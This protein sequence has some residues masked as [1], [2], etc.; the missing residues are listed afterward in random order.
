MNQSLH[1]TQSGTQSGTLAA[2]GTTGTGLV[3]GNEQGYVKYNIEGLGTTIQTELDD[4]TSSGISR[5]VPKLL[6]SGPGV[7]LE[8]YKQP[9]PALDIV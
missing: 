9:R 2:R 7:Q 4:S 3:G 1:T 6:Y 5:G 8:A